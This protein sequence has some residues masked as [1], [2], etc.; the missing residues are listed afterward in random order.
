MSTIATRGSAAGERV[1]R[2]DGDVVVEAEAHRP[3][4]FGVM[5]GRPHQRERRL[6][7]VERVIDRADGRAGGEQRDLARTPA[8]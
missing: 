7:G 2:G 8:T 5:P 6:A 3:I 1:R 4:A